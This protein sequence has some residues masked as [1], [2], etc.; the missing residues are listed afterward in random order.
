MKANNYMFKLGYKLYSIIS[1]W[2]QLE[3]KFMLCYGFMK[4]KQ[5][6][7]LHDGDLFSATTIGEYLG[8]STKMA[9]NFPAKVVPRLSSRTFFWQGESVPCFESV[10]YEKRKF[11]VEYSQEVFNWL[12]LGDDGDFYVDVDIRSLRLFANTGFALSLYLCLLFAKKST[13]VLSKEQADK[14]FFA[15]EPSYNNVSVQHQL[16]KK[17]V[18]DINTCSEVFVTLIPMKTGSRIIGWQF[19]VVHLAADENDTAA[20]YKEEYPSLLKYVKGAD[21]DFI[22]DKLVKIIAFFSK[23]YPMF[24]RMVDCLKGW[25]LPWNIHGTADERIEKH[26]VMLLLISL[27][28]EKFSWYTHPKILSLLDYGIMNN[29]MDIYDMIDTIKEANDYHSLRQLMNL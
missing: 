11:N 12:F 2:S 15:V 28:D 22:S 21:F 1:N 27:R 4:E 29:K 3:I 16:L 25:L 18:H 23:D 13:V 26:I 7:F 9:Y 6:L 8:L 10:S 5:S 19:D 20:W 14:L 17:A 24:C